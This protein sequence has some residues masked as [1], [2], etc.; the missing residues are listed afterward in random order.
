MDVLEVTSIKAAL[1]L[2]AIAL[3]AGILGALVN[4]YIVSPAAAKVGV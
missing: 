1:I 2:A 4:N 3:V